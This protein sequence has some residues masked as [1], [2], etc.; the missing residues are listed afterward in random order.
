MASSA[1]VP[2][3][4][5]YRQTLGLTHGDLSWAAVA[6]FAGA[7][8][9]LL[10]FARISDYLGRRIVIF[11]NLLLTMLGCLIFLDLAGF[12]M[13]LAGVLFK[14]LLVDWRPAQLPRMWWTMRRRLPP[15]LV[16]WL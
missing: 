12:P 8:I 15:G 4:A 1:P 14:A 7:V 5:I 16:L 10:M 6:Y 11:A 3:F 9:A 2:L 13:L